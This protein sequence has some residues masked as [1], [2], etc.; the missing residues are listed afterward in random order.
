M[1]TPTIEECIE[2]LDDNVGGY[3]TCSRRKCDVTA[4]YLQAAKEMRETLLTIRECLER[5]NFECHHVE[6][7]SE[8]TNEDCLPSTVL[9]ET[10]KALAA[11]RK[12]GEG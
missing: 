9:R 2:W 12:A 10:N 5:T 8:C 1:T 3:L 11:W 7:L 4:D 6:T